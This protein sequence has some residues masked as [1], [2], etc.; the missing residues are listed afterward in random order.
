VK[1]DKI[2]AKSIH[3][4]LSA[5][6]GDYPTS[7]EL[8][9]ES[10]GIKLVSCFCPIHPFCFVKPPRQTMTSRAAILEDD[11]LRQSNSL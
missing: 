1:L 7:A 6:M 10:D 9:P 8:C 2:N 11:F 4:T 3:L 5:T